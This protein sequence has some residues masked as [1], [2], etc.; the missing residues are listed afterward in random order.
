MAGWEGAAGGVA[1]AWHVALA[2][3]LNQMLRLAAAAGRWREGREAA[4]GAWLG[5]TG[6]AVWGGTWRNR[7]EGGAGGAGVRE[8][9][10]R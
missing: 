7:R 4:A 2:A 3:A 1:A 6:A 9:A 10:K 5:A 8:A